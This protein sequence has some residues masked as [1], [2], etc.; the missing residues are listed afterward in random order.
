MDFLTTMTTDRIIIIEVGKKGVKILIDT[1]RLNGIFWFII[2]MKI[3][4]KQ[5]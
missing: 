1:R 5:I 3:I 2:F 4:S